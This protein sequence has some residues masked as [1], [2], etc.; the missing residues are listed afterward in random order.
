MIFR[1]AGTVHPIKVFRSRLLTV[2]QA[3][4]PPYVHQNHTQEDL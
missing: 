1:D 2:K 4:M 3:S